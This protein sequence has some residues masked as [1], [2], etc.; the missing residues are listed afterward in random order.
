VADGTG[1]KDASTDDLRGYL[2]LVRFIDSD[3]TPFLKV[4]IGLYRV[5]TDRLRTHERNGGQVLEVVPT[6]RNR[7]Y[8]AEQA[9]VQRLRPGWGYRPRRH[10]S[11][12]NGRECFT[13]AAPI[14]LDR[15]LD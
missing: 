5:R 13:D 3:G 12:G 1:R 6:T 2:Y 15:C 14:R 11:W 9:I 10:G 7:A 4:G 8:R